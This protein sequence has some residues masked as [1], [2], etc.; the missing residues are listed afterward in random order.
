MESTIRAL[1][2]GKSPGPD[3]ILNEALKAC[4]AEVALA[5]AEIASK[6]LET[7]HFPAPLRKTITVVLR[8][9]DKNDY[10][11]P[12]CYRP[13]AL[14]NT[15]GKVIENLRDR[16]RTPHRCLGNGQPTAMVTD[17]CLEAPLNDNSTVPPY[18][19]SPHCLEEVSRG[20]LPQCSA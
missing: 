10:S 18:D 2:N 8:K 13:I 11:L 1:P 16:R 3:R 20:I 14:E 4:M 6:C 15:L 12:G 9:E 5:L 7:G 17:G 19:H